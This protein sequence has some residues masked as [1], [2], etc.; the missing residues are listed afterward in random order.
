MIDMGALVF[1]FL[2]TKNTKK[3]KFDRTTGFYFVINHV[4]VDIPVVSTLFA[5]LTASS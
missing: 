5:I 2:N 3:A 4:N 1:S